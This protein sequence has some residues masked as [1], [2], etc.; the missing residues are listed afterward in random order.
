MLQTGE[1]AES[2]AAELGLIQSSDT[3]AIDAAIDAAIS[4]NA[5]SVADYKAGK[6]AALGAIVGAV[7]KSQKGLNPRL[8]QQRLKEKLG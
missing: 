7:M 6:Q 8:V 4:A 1:R 3:S 5:K 2:A